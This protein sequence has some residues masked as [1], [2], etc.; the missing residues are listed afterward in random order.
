MGGGDFSGGFTVAALILGAPSSGEGFTSAASVPLPGLI[1][2]LKTL[3]GLTTFP[4]LY[5]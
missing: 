3:R 5:V 4:S 2:P 1:E